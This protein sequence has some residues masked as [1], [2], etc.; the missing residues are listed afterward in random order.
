M[1][2]LRQLLKW[3]AQSEMQ[4]QEAVE[5][6]C[7]SY[8]ELTLS[9]LGYYRNE[10]NNRIPF[11]LRYTLQWQ[12]FLAAYFKASLSQEGSNEKSPNKLAVSVGPITFHEQIEAR[13]QLR[14]W[15]EINAPQNIGWLLE[16]QKKPADFSIGND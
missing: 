7:G 9:L 14:Q 11:A 6:M 3:V 8:Q 12:L 1:D 10:K 15:L 2:E 5:T 16:G 13:H 4:L